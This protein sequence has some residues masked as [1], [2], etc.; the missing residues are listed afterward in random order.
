MRDEIKKAF[1]SLHA[2]DQTVEEVLSMIEKNQKK[3]RSAKSAK[4]MRTTIIAAALVAAMLACT[5]FTADYIINR[6][7]IFF[8]DTIEALTQKQQE[9]LDDPNAAVGYQI[10][11]S[12]EENSDM[13]TSA[14]YVA[15]AMESG[16]YGE[17]EEVISRETGGEED[18]WEQRMISECD[19]SYYGEIVAEYRTSSGYAEHVTVDGL[20]DWDLS[21][22]TEKMTPDEGGQMLS[23]CRHKQ[24]DDFSIVKLHLGYKTEDGGRFVLN[25]EYNTDW[26]YGEKTDYVLNS[27]YDSSELYTTVDNIQVLV[28]EY[29]GQ[30][31]ANA[32]NGYKSFDIYTDGCTVDEIKQ[33][34]D[35]LNLSSVLTME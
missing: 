30:V 17:N 32:V 22:L 16:F 35:Q 7:E 13:E 19:D 25:Y 20:L 6:R 29:D 5:A 1:S 27:A 14:E 11:N 3:E 21:C 34:L 9:D 8:F 23:F 4:M 10:P 28:Q 31:W 26:D 15:R 2:S 24:E 18:D 12:A 33:I